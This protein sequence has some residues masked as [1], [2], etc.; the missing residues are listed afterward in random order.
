MLYRDGQLLL[1]L[2]GAAE[3]TSGSTFILRKRDD[4]AAFA[5]GCLLTV[6]SAEQPGDTALAQ[7]VLEGSLTQERWFQLASVPVYEPG[8][9]NIL[10]PTDAALLFVRARVEVSQG[11]QVDGTVELLSTATIT[12]DRAP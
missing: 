4:V 10:L 7:V 6:T 5:L 12:S 2:E 3:D 8:E 9:L 11:A 1:T